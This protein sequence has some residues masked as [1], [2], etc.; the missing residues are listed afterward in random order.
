MKTI[1]TAIIPHKQ[2]FVKIKEQ[3]HQLDY[4]A[5]CVFTALGFF[6]DN[7]TYW[8]DTKVLRPATV[9]T[10][11]EDGYLIKSEKWFNW[12]YSPR[13]ISLENTVSEF[14]E[15]F[16]TIIKEQT[17]GKK[18]IL[19]LSG[20]LDSRT[21]A[22]A[23]HHLKSDVSSYSYSFQNGYKESSISEKIAKSLDISFKELMISK[24]YL[25]GKLG[26]LTAINNCYSEFTHPRQMAVIDEIGVLGNTFSLGHWGDVLFDSDTLEQLDEKNI[27]TSLKKKIVKKGGIALAESLWN[28]WS[29]DGT[30]M[31]YLNERLILLWNSI[32]IDN[33]AAKMRAFKSLYWAPRWTSINL[34]V[35]ESVQPITL[36]YYD[37]RM[38]E[39]ICSVPENLLANRQIQ[40]EYIKKRNSSVA[41][42]EW[43]D[44]RPFNL[45]TYRFNKLPYTIPYRLI[46]KLQRVVKSMLGEKHTQRNWEIQ[47][48]GKENNRELLQRIFETDFNKNFISEELV[49]N[50]YS[51][52]TTSDTVNYSHPLSMILTLYEFYRKEKENECKN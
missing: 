37:D 50:I 13:D 47:F 27:L 16:E 12:H 33:N 41:K 25:W 26:R 2:T 40:I 44:A 51:K 4:R 28:H 9:N 39:F 8:L 42:I 46:T 38:C 5:I 11:D 19:P 20:G 24:G 15:L 35:F 30:F 7:D 52:F 31:D 32:Q 14:S 23:L 6:L 43:Q 10:I 1:K 18:V 45:Y 34:A 17:E 3:P 36:P 21:Q 29:I 48:L 22:V 49:S